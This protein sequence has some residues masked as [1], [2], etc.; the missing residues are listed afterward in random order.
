MGVTL[1]QEVAAVSI[2]T[3]DP[4]AAPRSLGHRWVF[5]ASM[6]EHEDERKSLNDTQ[7]VT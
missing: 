5:T 2:H 3:L 7:K 6:K 4:E 1:L